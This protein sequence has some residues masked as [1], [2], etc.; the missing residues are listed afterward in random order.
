MGEEILPIAYVVE[1]RGEDGG[2]AVVS[3]RVLAAQ[4]LREA[5]DAEDVREVMGSIVRGHVGLDVGGD[6]DD[7]VAGE[8][9]VEEVGLET[10]CGD[11]CGEVCG[12][13][14]G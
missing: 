9:L 10:A 5:Q 2:D 8:A 14:G 4:S 3:G 6:L 12:W 1:E 11:I 13:C 7:E